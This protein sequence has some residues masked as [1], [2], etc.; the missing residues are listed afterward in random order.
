[1]AILKRSGPPLWA[2]ANAAFFSVLIWNS[3]SAPNIA[4]SCP[5]IFSM[6]GIGLL[7]QQEGS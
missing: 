2:F 4:W 5:V 1:M 3:P 7:A 6:V